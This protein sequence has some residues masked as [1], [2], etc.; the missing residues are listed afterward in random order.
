MSAEPATCKECTAGVRALKRRERQDREEG[1]RLQEEFP[2]GLGPGL[3][4]R[5]P[6]RAAAG[7]EGLRE[8]EMPRDPLPPATTWCCLRAMPAQQ[9]ADG[10]EQAAPPASQAPGC[11][12]G[13]GVPTC[14][15]ISLG[16]LLTS[17][18]TPSV[19]RPLLPSPGLAECV[20]E[21]EEGVRSGEERLGGR[22]L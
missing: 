19:Q 17:T 16:A 6:R 8:G 18:H 3:G 1:P 2:W 9:R 10:D 20:L 21:S 5:L 11:P 13:E 12:L 7:A 15:V 14:T 22:A 4:C